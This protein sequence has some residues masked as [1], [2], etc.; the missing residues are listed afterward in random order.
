M[1][2]C[3]LTCMHCN[4]NYFLKLRNLLTTNIATEY[5]RLQQ[6]ITVVTTDDG[7]SLPVPLAAKALHC[8]KKLLKW[9]A[10]FENKPKATTFA[11]TLVKTIMEKVEKS[12]KDEHLKEEMMLC[13]SILKEREEKEGKHFVI[14]IFV[15]SPAIILLHA[16]SHR[17]THLSTDWV[18]CID[19]GGLQHVDDITFSLFAAMELEFQRHTTD[20]SDDETIKKK[21]MDGILENDDVQVYWECLSIEWDGEIARSLL[22]LITEHWIT[23][24]V[25]IHRLVHS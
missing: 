6:A 1:S 17:S 24:Y 15:E 9:M 21:A 8:A 16:E 13:L 19:R 10:E 4:G 22:K 18:N 5:Q 14:A 3:Q 20:I 2:P 12:K 11:V 23:I 25:V 7:F